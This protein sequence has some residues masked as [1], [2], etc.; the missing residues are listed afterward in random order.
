MALLLIFCRLKICKP[1]PA[2]LSIFC[3]SDSFRKTIDRNT[4]GDIGI[5]NRPTKCWMSA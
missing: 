5:Y 3:H 2:L 1:K 4:A